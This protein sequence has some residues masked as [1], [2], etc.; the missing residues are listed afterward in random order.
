M[1]TT[2]DGMGEVIRILESNGIKDKFKVAVG[3][4]PISQAFADRIG[5]DGYSKNAAEAVRLC[6]RLC[7]PVL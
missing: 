3:G 6:R 5:A 1:T 4:G 7:E 2:M